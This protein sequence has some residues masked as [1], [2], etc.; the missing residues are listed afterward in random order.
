LDELEKFCFLPQAAFESKE[1][2]EKRAKSINLSQVAIKYIVKLIPAHEYQIS[3]SVP[4]LRN[5]LDKAVNA[6]PGDVL[7]GLQT[8]EGHIFKNKLF[9]RHCYDDL[10]NVVV[11]FAENAN[12]C[13]TGDPG[14]G[15]SAFSSYV[16]IKLVKKVY[17]ENLATGNGVKFV[18]HVGIGG[19]VLCF[20]ATEG[21]ISYFSKIQDVRE[22]V[23]KTENAW[24]LLDGW[25]PVVPF[26]EKN[27]KTIV[28]ASPR[29]ENYH[30]IIKSGGLK[31]FMPPWDPEEIKTLFDK[32]D[33][34]K[35]IMSKWQLE[36]MSTGVT[37]ETNRYLVQYLK[38]VERDQD[39]EGAAA[40]GTT[41][42]SID[43]SKYLVSIVSFLPSRLMDYYRIS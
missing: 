26:A 6:K 38:S 10:Y 18:F 14:V 33:E 34:K 41:A 24:L 4:G 20:D 1:E 23:W 9:V 16:F 39:E 3:V 35:S 27:Q 25:A 42:N 12:A 30:E 5:I 36:G 31:F 37:R 13:V 22:D 17:D 29:K 40:G 43:E 21:K 11:T 28:F 15:K 8:S 32:L 19:S 2:F 7:E